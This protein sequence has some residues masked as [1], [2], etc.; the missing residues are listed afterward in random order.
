MNEQALGHASIGETVAAYAN[1]PAYA[2]WQREQEDAKQNRTDA[3][4]SVDGIAKLDAIVR[5]QFGARSL[6]HGLL[7]T[8][9]TDSKHTASRVRMGFFRGLVNKRVV[10][11]KAAET[12]R[13]YQKPP[14]GRHFYCRCNSVGDELL[15]QLASPTEALN[16]VYRLRTVGRK[17]LGM[18]SERIKVNGGL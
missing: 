18:A 3:G 14:F 11:S 6:L 4:I 17:V 12:A 13:P 9:V 2:Q 8:I 1:N 5:P 15:A 10:D 16:W 7:H